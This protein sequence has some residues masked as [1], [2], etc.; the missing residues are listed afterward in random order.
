MISVCHLGKVEFW[1]YIGSDLWGKWYK[2][3]ESLAKEAD[4]EIVK[5]ANQLQLEVVPT[6]S[7]LTQQTNRLMIDDD[8]EDSQEVSEY[9]FDQLDEEDSAQVTKSQPYNVEQNSAKRQLSNYVSQ[10]EAHFQE[11][12]IN[13]QTYRISR[14]PSYPN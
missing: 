1:C 3:S 14:I 4:E 8:D 11:R 2:K 5:I 12:V 9:R 13:F 7:T 10:T 6:A